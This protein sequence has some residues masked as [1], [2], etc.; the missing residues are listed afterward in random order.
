MLEKIIRY[1]A[2]RHMLANFITIAVFLGAV[3]AWQKTAKEEMPN[4]ELNFI[5]VRT[6]YPGA[7][8]EDVEQL[9]TKRLEREL[10]GIDG[11]YSI[12]STSTSGSSQI[13]IEFAPGYDNMN[14][15]LNDIR[16]QI[17][18]V[19]L[20]SEVRNQPSVRQYKTTRRAVMD[21]AVYLTNTIILTREDRAVLQQYAYNLSDQI[22]NLPQVSE[23]SSSGYYKN[24]LQV[25]LD[26]NK[27]Q[28]YNVSTSEVIAALRRNNLRVPA[29]ALEDMNNTE[30]SVVAELD[31]LD[32]L[33]SVIIR[34]S[35]DSP[36]VR[37]SDLA[38]LRKGFARTR[39]INKIN[40][41]EAVIL[42]VRKT[43]DSDIIETTDKIREF[44]EQYQKQILDHSP[45][46]TQLLSDASRDV[47]NRLYI[48]VS[49]GL[50]GFVLIIIFLFL[51]MDARSAFWVAMGIPFTFCLTAICFPLLGYSINNTTLSAVII[52]MG[53]IVDDAIVVAENVARHYYGGE[54]LFEAI[55]HG[56]R[57][58]FMPVLGSITTT[59]AAFIPLL[60]FSGRYGQMLVFIP[61]IVIIMLMGSFFETLFILPTH[62]NMRLPK[63]MKQ[64]IERLREKARTRRDARARFGS[65]SRAPKKVKE[66]WFTAI[67]KSYA[68][69]LYRI[70]PYRTYILILFALLIVWAGY[71][72]S[73]HLKF[74]LFP[75]EVSNEIIV[76][77]NVRPGATRFETEEI[78]RSLEEII[79]SEQPGTVN[80]YRTSIARNRRG[81]E[82]DQTAFSITVELLPREEREKA[83]D[84]LA[85]HWRKILPDLPDI[86]QVLVSS[87]RFGSSS[88]SV[89]EIEVRENND[90]VRRKAAEMVRDALNVLPKISGAEVDE[91]LR[92]PEY[93]INLNRELITR[94]GINPSDVSA[95]L[96][97][98]LEGTIVAELNGGEEEVDLRVSID[99]NYKQSVAWMLQNPVENNG[100]YLVPIS[101]LVNYERVLTPAAITRILHKRT[102]M[103]YA[104]P[105]DE[106]APPTLRRPRQPQ[107][108]ETAEAPGSI[109]PDPRSLEA[110]KG[111]N[112]AKQ[113]PKSPLIKEDMTPIEVAVYLE[114]EVFPEVHKVYPGVVF[115]FSGEI[116]DTRESSGDIFFAV[117]LVIFFIFIILSLIFGSMIR[118]LIIM[119]TIPFGMVGVI[120]TFWIHGIELFGLFAAIGALG[121]AGVVI[122]D[123]IVMLDKLDRSVPADAKGK[124]RLKLIAEAGAT[125]LKAVTLTTVTTVAAIM[126]TAY[127]FFGYDAMLAQMML[128][129]SW[130]LMFGTL[131]TLVLIPCIYT[132]IKAPVAKHSGKEKAGWSPNKL[133][134]ALPDGELPD[135]TESIPEPRAARTPASGS[136]T[137]GT[138]ASGSRK[139][140]KR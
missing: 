87:S 55:V 97:T 102:T 15:A 127:G 60:F 70:L 4:Y 30:V 19:R 88:G 66:H 121:L 35:F 11:V 33:Q 136:R 22:G 62:L 26:P 36:A 85:R 41:R 106:N 114:K 73:A 6:A 140:G 58:V 93:R 27:L 50:F 68:R 52:V 67:E 57:E 90:T 126:P 63:F 117:I 119:L 137:R 1:F 37:L 65:A 7:S 103:V 100:N 134:F 133:A 53:M 71:I 128:V 69:L 111:M 108:N 17:A 80:S 124:E 96:R 115:S 44:V 116:K 16:N 74:V 98:V 82:S 78:V 51:F 14:G 101:Q 110:E 38:S 40:G 92:N 2:Q 132:L 139:G 109:M 20:P 13:T 129:L 125:R 56:T 138:P 135:E 75:D 99:E 131:I 95:A 24:E 77:G 72:F 29:G 31:S 107:T 43:A 8:P 86:D 94:L 123:S 25:V 9:V 83:G 3:V 49:N 81:R 39:W 104:S 10:K 12:R 61:P 84:D 47:R 122:N 76:Y 112:A 64:A 42:N 48:V 130:G 45:V 5:S 89:I 120:L 54:T 23:V 28:Q 105:E 91:P 59:C 113:K 21:V 118:P 46:Q 79:E 34:S 32:Q 18:D